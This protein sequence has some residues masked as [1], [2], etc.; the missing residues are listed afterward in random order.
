MLVTI[1]KLWFS[2]YLIPPSEFFPV[3]HSLQSLNL[4]LI[5][6]S[7]IIHAHFMIACVRCPITFN[8]EAA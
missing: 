8:P 3:V 2:S 6:F 5:S 1:V 7:F 4:E